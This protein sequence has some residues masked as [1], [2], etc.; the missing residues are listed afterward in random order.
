M[1]GPIR[2]GRGEQHQAFFQLLIDQAPALLLRR[3]NFLQQHVNGG[4]RL[5]FCSNDEQNTRNKP[6][7]VAVLARDAGDY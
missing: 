3:A 2:H 5:N 1:A 7:L 6:D 4:D